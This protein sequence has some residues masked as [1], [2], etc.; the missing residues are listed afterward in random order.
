[1]QNPVRRAHFGPDARSFS[2]VVT[3]GAT[4]TTEDSMSEYGKVVILGTGIMGRALA[5]RLLGQGLEV[6]VWNR[7]ASRAEPLAELGATIAATPAEAVA[8]ADTV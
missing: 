4:N 6:T 5:E 7:T 2:G 3:W 1:M 8:G